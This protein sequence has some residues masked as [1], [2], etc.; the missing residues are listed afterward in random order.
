MEVVSSLDTLQNITPYTLFDAVASSA[1]CCGGG[2]GCSVHQL[3]T[4]CRCH[5]HYAGVL[6]T[7][8]AFHRVRGL[9]VC[10]FFFSYY[11][12]IPTPL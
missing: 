10:L 9:R 5:P 7:E 3:S 1:G 2:G 6:Y 4:D 12:P 11:S 8:N